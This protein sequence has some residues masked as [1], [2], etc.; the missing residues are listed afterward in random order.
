MTIFK[1]STLYFAE[2]LTKFIRVFTKNNY[3]MGDLWKI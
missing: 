3:E 2:W 1:I